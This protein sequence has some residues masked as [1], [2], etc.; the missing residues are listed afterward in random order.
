MDLA[1]SSGFSAGRSADRAEARMT[2]KLPEFENPPVVEVAISLQFKPLEL[3]RAAHFGILWE[4]LRREGFSRIEDHG[5]LEPAFE[6]FG[7]RS[8]GRVGV[9]FQAFDDAPPLPRIWFL[10]EARN[11]LIQVQ[12][13]RLIVN[14]RVGARS[15][16][17]PR[18]VNILKR[19]RSALEI[20]L[21]FV[22]AENLGDLVPTQ[23]E[24]TYVNHM[25]AGLGWTHHGEIYK[26]I[27]PWGNV[28][29]DSYLST[30]EDVGFVARFRMEAETGKPIGRLHVNFQPANRSSD[31]QPIFAMNLTARG[32]PDPPDLNGAFRLFDLEHEWIVRGFTSLTTKNMHDI[33]RRKNGG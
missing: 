17:Y 24:V 13:D 22:G 29:S 4:S 11:E 20:F 26:V 1:Q 12:R 10:N 14:W 30:P 18:Y 21:A 19:F 8:S 3:I 27:C 9:R 7:P 16:P 31:G 15:E 32:T 5:E 23:C 6:E 28:Y 33:W 2:Q 25:P